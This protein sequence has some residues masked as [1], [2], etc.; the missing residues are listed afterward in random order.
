[1]INRGRLAGRVVD[2]LEGDPAATVDV[3]AYAVPDST[4]PPTLPERPAYR[5]QTDSDGR[6]A[7]DFLSEQPYFVIGL[8]DLNR[9]AR[10]D[11]VEPFAVPPD[12]FLIADSLGTPAPRP[13]LLT[14]LDTIPPALQRVRAL[15]NRRLTLRFSESIQ[16]LDTNPALWTVRDS[17]SRQVVPVEAVY[18]QVEDP[19]QVFVETAPLFAS[20]HTIQPGGLADSSLNPVVADTVGFSP[21]AAQ[22][23][24]QVR[25]VSF[26]PAAGLAPAGTVQTLFPGQHP[27]M[28]LS[29]P[30]AA[31]RLTRI[32]SLVDSTGVAFPYAASTQD[33]VTYTLAPRLPMAAGVPFSLRVTG[34]EVGQPDTVFTRTFAYLSPDELGELSGVAR[35]D[36]GATGAPVVELMPYQPP[37]QPIPAVATDAE[38]RF[39]FSNLPAQTRYRVRAFLDRNGNM[40]WDGGAIAPFAFAEPIQ[41][42][43]DSLT[44]RARWATELSDTLTIK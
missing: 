17:V 11:G 3:F 31:E 4:L 10:P 1:M 23:T 44:V 19:R 12:S 14:Q 36:S 29:A 32:A 30:V 39:L 24:V 9:N 22:D 33:G 21:S 8:R 40:R 37:S 28:R 16:F 41:W 13:W 26:A 35:A 34:S 43:T 25:F 42:S 6:F 5:T 15:S 18:L 2:A 27:G 7:F 20:R 38:G